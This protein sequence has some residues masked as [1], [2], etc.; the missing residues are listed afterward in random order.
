MDGWIRISEYDVIK[1]L[2]HEVFQVRSDCSIKTVIYE[3]LP[4]KLKIMY[5]CVYDMIH[6]LP[7]KG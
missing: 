5:I 6:L 4:I 7:L 1:Y 3:S 2:P